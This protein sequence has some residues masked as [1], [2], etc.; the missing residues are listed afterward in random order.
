MAGKRGA[1]W[2]KLK[3]NYKLSIS[4]ETSYEELFT[5]RLSR[6][7]VIMGLSVLAVVLVGLT[8]LLIAFT[9]LKEFIPGFPD[10]NMRRLIT[11]NALRVDSMEME[12][13]KKDAYLNSIKSI[14]Q[15]E[16]VGV[17]EVRSDS[18]LQRYDTIQFSISEEES[19]FRAAMEERE[20]FNLTV[21]RQKESSEYY[22]F[23]SPVEGIVS[24]GFDEKS[25]HYGTDI[26]AK[27]N[28]RVSAVM[29]GVVCFTD[30][31]IKTGYVIQVQHSNNLLSIYKHN[32]TLLKKQGDYVMA[33]EVIAIVGNTGEETTGPHL[34]F[35]LWR[36]G[37]PLNPENFI[38]FK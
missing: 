27:A 28:S 19:A 16:E 38:Q 17:R 23:F 6:L 14:L 7:R 21:S 35:E 18:L 2:K 22:H 36:S 32:S 31:T 15:G 13:Q 37:N 12:L 9:D 34:H 20:R 30:W 29:D 25:R 4:N 24:R 3:Y 11:E 10:G 8:T 1:F 33:G 26:V 5:M